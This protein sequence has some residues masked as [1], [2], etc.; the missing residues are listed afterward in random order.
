MFRIA[1]READAATIASKVL[2]QLP[3]NVQGYWQLATRAEAL[4]LLE[5]DAAAAA[6][7]QAA[8]KAADAE[9]GKLASTLRQ[10]RRL[11]RHLEA[12]AAVLEPFKPR[13]VLVVAGQADKQPRQEFHVAAKAAGEAYITIPDEEALSRL[14]RSEQPDQR[15]ALV[16]PAPL[17]TLLRSKSIRGSGAGIAALIAER[18][19]HVADPR[20]GPVTA[21]RMRHTWRRALGLGLLA[22]LLRETQVMLAPSLFALSG[23]TL[24]QSAGLGIAAGLPQWAASD[25]LTAGY[26]ALLWADALADRELP[27]L[28]PFAKPTAGAEFQGGTL[29]SFALLSDAVRVA[30]DLRTASLHLGRGL[31]LC[32]DVEP[33]GTSALADAQLP[34]L[35]PA[36][37][38]NEVYATEAAAAEMTLLR[39]AL[40]DLRPVGR[41]RSD[42]RL[43]RIP[44]WAV[45]RRAF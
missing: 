10:L 14:C 31:K 32:L 6:A 40:V 39:P 3:D 43:N 22:A 45:T 41:V 18:P 4:L 29:L 5:Q 7:A 28:A 26:S 33:L 19:C 2:R 30:L 17:E 21:E 15:L 36:T 23:G 35:R 20:S 37:P 9:D 42:K 38:P 13:P 24:L 1:S 34:K 16:L 27:T 25:D 12:P 8:V 11:A 44:L